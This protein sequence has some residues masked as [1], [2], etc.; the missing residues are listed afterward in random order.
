MSI[1][2]KSIAVIAILA[3]TVA[4]AFSFFATIQVAQ[5][6][7]LT[8][9]QVDAIVSLLQSFGADST[10]IANVQASLNGQ[11]TTGSGS[12]ST[13]GGSCA[14][15]FT[16]TLQVGSSGAEVMNL[17]KF[18]N[19]DAATQVA[20]SGAGSP[21]SETST[22]G[23]ATKAAVIKFQ[24]K[25]AAD[26]LAPAGLSA[27]TGYWG[28]LSRAKANA[29]C[30]GGSTGGSTP[31]AG[32]GLSVGSAA[33]P[34]NG[35]AVQGA[36][37][38]PFT[39]VTLTAGND[40]D[41][42][43]NGIVV[44]RV[45][46]GSDAAFSGVVLLN[47]SGMQLGTAKTFNS[48]HQAT[49]GGTFTIPK[50]TSR[51]YTVA[52]N[53]NASLSA[54]AGEAPAISV[55]SVNTT[56]TVAGS[57]PITGAYHTINST[58]S[59][60]SL[61]LASSQ[62][63]ASNA[64]STKSL[65][66]TG[67][68]FTGFNLTANSAEDISLRSI[69]VNQTGSASASDLANVAIVVNGTAYPAVL[70]SD[71][72]YYDATFGSG[73]VIPKGNKVEVYVQ[74]D[75]VGSNASGRTVQFH[76]DRS[77][78]IY[79]TGQTYGY[80][81]AISGGAAGTPYFYGM[82]V[83]VNGASVTTI[84]KD[85][86]V[87]AQNIS[88]NVLNQPLGGFYVDLVGES[89]TVQSMV[90]NVA[91]S[92]S[93]GGKLTNVTLV[94]ENGSVVA[95]PV[96]ASASGST[97]TFTDSVTFKTGNHKYKLLGKVNPNA[98]NG[99]TIVISTTPSSGWTNVRGETSGNSITLSQS[100]FSMNT[101]TVKSGTL[102]IGRASSPASQ[103][104]VPG[105]VSVLMA[106][107]Q[108][109]ASQSGE[110]VRFAAAPLKLRFDVGS[111]EGAPNK[112]S[113]CQL[114]DGTTA[115]NTGSNVLNPSTS[116]TT[117]DP[118]NNTITLDN[119]VTVT[120]GTVKTLGVR[121]NVAST[122]DNASQFAWDVQDA[123]NWTF[124]GANSGST[125]SG[126]DA[127]GDSTIIVTI[128]AG[129][130]TVT[131]DASSPSYK[132]VS[133]G[134]TDVT[135]GAMK[136]HASNEAFNM[137]KLGLSLTN[138]ASSSSGDL[139]KVNIYDGATKVGEAYFS[140]GAT[141][142]TSTLMTVVTVPKDGDKVLT[143]KA[144][145]ADIGTG[146]AVTFSGHLLAVDYLN[147]EGTGV[148]S[149]NTQQLSTSAGSTAVAGVR[150]LK[151][152]PTVAKDTLS[153]TGLADGELMRFKVTADAKG[154]ISITELNFGFATTSV[155]LS[156]VNVYVYEDAN[157]STGA[158][159]LQSGGM[160][161]TT[162]PVGVNWVSSAS[163]YEFTAYNGSASTTLNIP[164]GATRYFAVRGSVA[165]VVSGSSITTTLKGASSFTT[166]ATPA[167]ATTNPLCQATAAFGNDFIWSP[168]S[169]TTPVRADQDWTG[170]YGV[171]G[172]PSTGLT[173]TRS[174]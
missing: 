89:I 170:G 22:F 114:F 58:L 3:V 133:A 74:G 95:G 17:Q 168:N 108:F 61:T 45:G 122:A 77:S 5:A 86:S 153:A 87:A 101:M 25:Y 51:T 31:S 135:I 88:L 65:G 79:A 161:S 42:T 105:G 21:G 76:I 35:L 91:T 49:V 93:I 67:Y 48:N 4:I 20:A 130:T 55:V 173:N 96:D 41:V 8:Q 140:S 162:N 12:G 102:T 85:T 107:V 128:G 30:V 138:S 132:T 81:S 152:Y 37:R 78:D 139:V 167:A 73:I 71:G 6:A 99:A 83:T 28:A 84:A 32:T 142:A 171:S 169:T 24:N 119:P 9:S 64:S 149:G 118:D 113:S 52:A 112:L 59:T 14:F 46:F 94:D 144:D 116:A 7:A 90:F 72:K 134:S 110:D 63:Y 104:I 123:T 29:M 16:Q 146:Q 54:Y 172:L 23:P 33:Q 53:M 66:T 82:T 36:I 159:G 70:S 109:D 27:G 13:S 131:T 160:F 98:T 47:D 155:T 68:K 174:Q 165:G 127:G 151:S 26:V 18:L 103:T 143:L 115:L 69:R 150:V 154:P 97:I 136:F 56:A 158:S 111:F 38:I 92:A 15:T 10:T 50:G 1:A 121:C 11:P 120:K 57:M 34:A 60:G 157:Y 106:N 40:G 126:A 100:S 137:T 43:V 62:A 148:D 117:T 147:A 145:L 156:N 124:T 163:N 44:Q 164:A 80:G 2:K 141:V 39:K 166:C 125:I 19:M 129:S 75:I